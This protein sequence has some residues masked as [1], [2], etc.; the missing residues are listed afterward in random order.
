MQRAQVQRGARAAGFITPHCAGPARN[1]PG[2]AAVVGTMFNRSYDKDSHPMPD[3]FDPL[4]VKSWDLPNRLVMAPL[5]RN[6]A[7]RGHGPRRPRRGVLR[8]ARRPPA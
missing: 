7:D 1:V 5:T 4:R 6:R 8:A 3:L 2:V